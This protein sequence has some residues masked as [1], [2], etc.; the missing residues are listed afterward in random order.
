MDLNNKID[1]LKQKERKN[2]GSK[3]E[4]EEEVR[5]V[6]NKEKGRRGERKAGGREE[7]EAGS[8]ASKLLAPLRGDA[9]LRGPAGWAVGP[10]KEWG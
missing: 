5:E 3:G 6:V 4:R 2:K 9:L 7:E 1:I 10:P 8:Q